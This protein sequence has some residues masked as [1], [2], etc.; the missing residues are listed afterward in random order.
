MQDD[1]KLYKKRVSEESTDE[2]LV[3]ISKLV[4]KGLPHAM[5]IGLIILITRR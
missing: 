5:T 4:R 3:R 2:K 1:L